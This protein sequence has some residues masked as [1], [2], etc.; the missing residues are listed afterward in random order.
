MATI[1]EEP[2]GT[3][4]QRYQLGEEL[5]RGSFAIVHRCVNK[6][7]GKHF[8]VKV[9]NK[10]KTTPSQLKDLDTEIK[11]MRKLQH[12]FVITLYETVASATSLYIVLEY[13]QGGDLFHM[14]S[15]LKHYSE[16]I[17]AY[18]MNNLM[19]ALKYMHE[20]G[21]AH[22]DLK[23]DN[24]LLV[25]AIP[26]STAGLKYE[27][28]LLSEIKVA[29]FGFAQ[30]CG[31]RNDMT[32]CCGTPYYIA[33]EVLLCG[34]YKTGPPY[35][36]QADLWSAGVICY[37]LLSGSPAFQAQKRDALF[38]LIVQGDISFEGSLWS[39]ISEQAKDFITKLLE[40]D[41]AVRLTP[42]KALAH[43]WLDGK[44]SEVHLPNLQSKLSTF[45]ARMKFKGAVFGIEAAH[46]M[47]Y[48]G[49]CRNSG[50]RP[51]SGVVAMMEA[52]EGEDEDDTLDL[53]RNYVGSKGI[54]AIM[55]VVAAKSKLKKLML[56]ANEIENTDVA[57]VVST[58]EKH[59]SVTHIDFSNNPISRV[60]AKKLYHLV[61]MNPC[62]QRLDLEGTQIHADKIQAI[63]AQLEKNRAQL[64]AACKEIGKKVPKE[65][66]P[67]T[68]AESAESAADGAAVAAPG[69]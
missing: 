54:P 45:N 46:R 34:L 50:I 20:C 10:Q 32:K 48:L 63:E 15:R 7:N 21:V 61:Q 55:A 16:N 40:K 17:A 42:E 1:R 26:K 28:K 49:W 69:E 64:A 8:A 59:P 44:Q 2:S 41:P 68:K 66:R 62:I 4:T 3:F 5:G 27:T 39:R 25:N 19:S 12:N 11:I 31:D 47:L 22:R 29:D 60:A 53:N 65:A 13:V 24:M 30:E 14:I 51:N 9:V 18:L 38:K 58:L 67:P 35:G 6:K 37:V 43:E 56:A 57:T 52:H 23:P 33:P 36:K